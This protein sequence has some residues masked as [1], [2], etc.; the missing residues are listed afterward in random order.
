MRIISIP[1]AGGRPP[2]AIWNAAVNDTRPHIKPSGVLWLG[3]IPV[4]WRII[5]AG[6]VKIPVVGDAIREPYREFDPENP[7]PEPVV[8]IQPI[9]TF[10][11]VKPAGS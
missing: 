6:L 10:R 5:A 1:S 11:N 9:G 2:P 3:D 8:T 7:D 4:G